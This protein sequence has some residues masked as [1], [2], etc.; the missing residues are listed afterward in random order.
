MANSTKIP[1]WLIPLGIAG[2]LFYLWLLIPDLTGL[3]WSEL[4]SPL[5]H[6]D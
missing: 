6:I 1:G 4:L 3:T 2:G 5:K